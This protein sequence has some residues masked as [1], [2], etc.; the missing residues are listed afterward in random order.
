MGGEQCKDFLRPETQ[1]VGGW[2]VGA[3][4]AV[5]MDLLSLRLALHA[6]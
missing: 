1:W 4:K 3:Y 6:D 5:A 2:A